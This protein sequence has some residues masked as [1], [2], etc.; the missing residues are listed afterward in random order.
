VLLPE[1]C[2][3]EA[4]IPLSELSRKNR[5]KNI[6]ALAT[7]GH[8]IVCCVTSVDHQ[9]GAI[10]LTKSRVSKQEVA[11]HQLKYGEAELS[12]QV[13]CRAA[14]LSGQQPAE[15]LQQ[16]Y[17]TI[18]WP[19]AAEHGTVYSALQAA[20]SDPVT[21]C[22]SIQPDTLL[23]ELLLAEAGRRMQAKAVRCTASVRLHCT[24]P[25]GVHAVRSALCTAEQA[26]SSDVVSFN[27]EVPP[28]YRLS[29]ETDPA[30]A[31]VELWRAV[32]L[33]E[34][35]A[36]S[37]GCTFQIESTPHAAGSAA[38]LQEPAD[39]TDL[40]TMLTK[41]GA[42]ELVGVDGD[43]SSCEEL[44]PIALPCIDETNDGDSIDSPQELLE[45][46]QLELCAVSHDGNAAALI[47][48]DTAARQQAYEELL[49]DAVSNDTERPTKL[50]LSSLQ[51]LIKPKQTLIANFG[52]ICHKLLRPFAHVM[53]FLTTELGTTG[54]VKGDGCGLTLK[55]RFQ[56]GQ[57]EVLVRRYCAQ[58]VRCRTC[59]SY[60]STMQYDATI[61]CQVQQCGHCH[62]SHTLP[63]IKQPT[64]KAQVGRRPRC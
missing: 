6:K 8:Y 36:R 23:L 33:I 62:A 7:P 29:C 54:S 28:V 49:E 21:A 26:L 51:I 5:V 64:Y 43:A 60:G 44:V 1:Y 30:V 57:I 56:P 16:M 45:E 42:A 18:G 15:I 61:R 25:L 27:V 24:G 48:L 34:A 52:Q 14:T 2:S 39:D 47:A 11:D 40:T 41:C 13:L 63:S 35:D 37:F 19:L 4:F 3:V 9:S 50:R 31:A 59:G 10:D 38:E 53:L 12:H 17:S 32:R 22:S 20:L 46:Q 55:G 58:F